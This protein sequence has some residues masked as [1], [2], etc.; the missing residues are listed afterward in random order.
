MLLAEGRNNR[1]IAAALSVT[2]ATVKSHLVRVYA[3]LEASNRN[4]A[5]AERSRSGTCS[6]VA[7]FEAH[8]GHPADACRSAFQSGAPVTLALADPSYPGFRPM[9]E[10]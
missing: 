3:K 7:R 5:S 2:L 8:R 1:E 4:E 10:P 9:R 6:G